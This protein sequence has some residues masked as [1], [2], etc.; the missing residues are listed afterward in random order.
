MPINEFSFIENLKLKFNYSDPDFIGIG[1]DCAITKNTHKQQLHSTDCLVE[2]IHFENFDENAYDIG[3][4]LVGV[5]LSDIAAMGGFPSTGLLSFAIPDKINLSALNSMIDGIADCCTKYDLKIIGG[6]TSKSSGPIFL[7]LAITG[8]VDNKPILR[9]GA[10][11]GDDIYVT[12]K[13][14]GSLLSR[15][16]KVNPRLKEMQWL[17][18]FGINAAIDVSDG[19]L[20][21]LGHIC[22]N[23]KCFVTLIENNIPIHDDAAKLIKDLKQF[24][25]TPLEG[26]FTDGEDFEIIFTVPNNKSEELINN[27]PFNDKL[28]CI[29]NIT[30]GP[31]N[32]LELK[33][34][35]KIKLE[36]KSFEHKF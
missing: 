24:N 29:G 1:D 11:V 18:S 2:G 30:A 35:E 22:E 33:S 16:Y 14:G 21:D 23:S 9:D 3:W 8:Y 17:S 32:S 13:L 36:M 19:L 15:H 28:Y 34:G 4:K 20:G 25:K 6:D 26:A 27:W 10:Q 31:D 5:N 12:G 7:N